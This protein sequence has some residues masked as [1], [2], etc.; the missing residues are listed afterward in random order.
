MDLS[1]SNEAESH[2]YYRAVNEIFQN[3]IKDSPKYSSEF[4]KEITEFLM[5]YCIRMINKNREE[6]ARPYLD[7]FNFLESIG[8]L[9]QSG[10]LR[11]QRLK[12]GLT[13]S[14]ITQ[15]H[16][17]L[18]QVGR[19]YEKLLDIPKPSRGHN[20]LFSFLIATKELHTKNGNM[21]KAADALGNYENSNFYRKN[22]N[23]KVACDKLRI[24]YFYQ[25]GDFGAYKTRLSSLWDYLRK[26][27]KMPANK[28]AFQKR[29]VN[30]FRKYCDE[31]GVRIMPEIEHLPQTDRIWL[32]HQ[33]AREQNY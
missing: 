31:Q 8:E 19:K 3:K 33:K 6:Y 15:D 10:Q 5:N 26:N 29:A 2:I 24:K 13:A 16:K 23:H 9:L 7:H 1:L 4:K 20:P 21:Q 30:Y 18:D 27:E 28:K 32:L 14:L 25:T 17:W 12:N 11:F 22:V